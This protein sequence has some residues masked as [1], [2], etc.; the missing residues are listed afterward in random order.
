M[1]LKSDLEGFLPE[2]SGGGHQLCVADF[3][4]RHLHQHLEFAVSLRKVRHELKFNE[5]DSLKKVRLA[6][7]MLLDF[8]PHF[9]HSQ[10]LN[11]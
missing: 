4:Q 9:C 2:G 10:R 8:F 11:I 7:K 1:I 5:I 3:G 6:I